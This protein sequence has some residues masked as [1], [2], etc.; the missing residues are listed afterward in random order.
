MKIS[1]CDDNQNELQDIYLL[2][3]KYIQNSGYDA[4]ILKFQSAASLLAYEKSHDVSDIYIL[5]I[6]MPGTDG[7]DLGHILY[8]RSP[9]SFILYLTNSSEFAIDAFSVKAFSYLIKP[10]DERLLFQELDL[11]FDKLSLTET[12]IKIRSRNGIQLLKLNDVV[13]VEYFNHHLIYHTVN[14]RIEGLQQRE[15]FDSSV[16]EFM[17][18][19]CFLKISASHIMNVRHIRSIIGDDFIMDDGSVY[20]IT[21]R[22]TDAKKKYL[23]F[24]IGE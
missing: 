12:Q 22:Y 3:R 11:L 2:V 6:I 15:S 4:E 9:R 1:I 20:K 16:S 14:E 10:V 7:I 17:E 24:I 5:D 13:A 19:G 23:D 21:R 8:K 18:S